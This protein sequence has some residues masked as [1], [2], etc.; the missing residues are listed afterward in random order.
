MASKCISCGFSFHKFPG[1]DH[2]LRTQEKG[3]NPL[4]LTPR[5]GIG[6][7]DRVFGTICIG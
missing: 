3:D 6:S 2:R 5:R 7:L 1:K 4:E